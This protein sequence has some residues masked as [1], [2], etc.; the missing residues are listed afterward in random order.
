MVL[1]LVVFSDEE[2]PAGVSGGMPGSEDMKAAAGRCW[3]THRDGAGIRNARILSILSHQTRR[4]E[5]MDVK[6]EREIL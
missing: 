5:E 1:G 2:G 6:S 4:R 3:V